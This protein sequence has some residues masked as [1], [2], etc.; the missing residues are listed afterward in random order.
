MPHTGFDATGDVTT[1]RTYPDTRLVERRAGI[2]SLLRAEGSRQVTEL[3]QELGVSKETIRRDLRIL[4]DEGVII[5]KHGRALAAEA[6]SFETTMTQRQNTLLP[7]KRRIAAAAAEEIRTA[8][9]IFI[10]EGYT[11]SVVAKLV[12]T[13]RNRVFVTASLPTAA[14]L[15]NIPQFTVYLAGGRVRGSTM[16][17]VDHWTTAMLEKFRFDVAII[18]ANGISISNGLTTPDPSV[19][20]VKE[21]AIRSA[22]RTVFVGVYTKFGITS[23][24]QFGTLKDLD[25]IVTDTHMP[26]HRATH[27]AVNGPKVLRV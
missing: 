7:E 16:G 27:F 19:A 26:A 2:L 1:P 5:R 24:A 12:S 6:S 15:M 14:A 10:D 11:P 17:C 4:E 23:F 3:A 8:E 9:T 20:I 25:L 21:T 22:Q 18:G 13:D